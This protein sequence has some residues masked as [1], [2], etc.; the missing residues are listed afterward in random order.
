MENSYIIRPNKGEHPV[1]TT[2]HEGETCLFPGN[3]ELVEK[4]ASVYFL[5]KYQRERSFA[6]KQKMLKDEVAL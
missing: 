6:T 3:D 1:K 4:S 2:Q 5:M